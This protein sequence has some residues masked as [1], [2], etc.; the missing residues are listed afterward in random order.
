MES[1]KYQELPGTNSSHP[2]NEGE[3][4]TRPDDKQES[5]VR[6]WS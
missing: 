4:G 3:D 5:A 1:G 6:N 2:I